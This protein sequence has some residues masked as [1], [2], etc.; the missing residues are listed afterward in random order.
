MTSLPSRCGLADL[1]APLVPLAATTT[2]SGSTSP[3][4]SAGAQRQGDRGRVAAG[5]GDPPGAAQLLPL[6]GQLGQAVG[7][8]AGVLA[9]VPARPGGRV[10]QPVVGAAVDDQGV[11]AAAARR[12]RRTPRAAGRGRRRRSRPAPPASLG[13]TSRSAKGSRCG[14]SSPRRRPALELACTPARRRFGCPAS[15]RHTSPPAY[16]VAPVTPTVHVCPALTMHDHTRPCMT[17]HAGIREAEGARTRRAGS[18][19]SSDAATHATTGV[20][21]VRV[22]YSGRGRRD[23]ED[24]RRPDRLPELGA[25]VDHAGR[26]RPRCLVDIRPHRGRRDGRE[27]ESDA[28]H[29]DPRAHQHRRSGAAR[30]T[31]MPTAIRARPRAAIRSR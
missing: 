28:G 8:G 16:P 1:P 6:A 10:G 4:A 20:P 23:Q 29:G 12:P 21:V 11:V 15:S 27:S 18:P 19:A 31:A 25:G 22:R 30:G 14:C 26:R 7:P 24:A 2:T 17:A 3:A 5:D 9:A 13:W